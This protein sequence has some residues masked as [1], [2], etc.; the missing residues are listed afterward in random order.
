MFSTLKITTYFRLMGVIFMP[1][2]ST[3]EN[4]AI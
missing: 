2:F 3:G 1:K 4:L